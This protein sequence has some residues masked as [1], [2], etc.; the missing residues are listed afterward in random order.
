MI[1]LAAARR[2]ASKRLPLADLLAALFLAAICGIV[3]QQIA[4]SFVRQGMAG[5]TPYDDAASYPR[6]VAVVVLALLVVALVQAFGRRDDAIP[7][8]APPRWAVLV[9][10]AALVAVFAL[11]LAGL[12]LVG[13][14][15]ATPP[16]V[17]AMMK[18]A[19]ARRNGRVALVA[20]A[21]ML[22]TAIMFEE[23]LNV[24]LPGGAI[25]WNLHWLW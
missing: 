7:D 19:G 9:R 22:A 10:P 14:S 21:S 5:G 24:V 13:Y 23:G 25:N 6:A 4:T 18:V 15:L 3:F 20:V 11:Y 2:A 12:G 8:E 1:R 16:A 17:Y